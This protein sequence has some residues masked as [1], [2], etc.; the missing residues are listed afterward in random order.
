MTTF[1]EV[2]SVIEDILSGKVDI[3]L[4]RIIESAQKRKETVRK[5]RAAQ[6]RVGD[7]IVIRH[8]RPARFVN[9][10]GTVISPPY[11]DP[12]GQARVKVQV[13]IDQRLWE[14]LGREFK[15]YFEAPRVMSL[16]VSTFEVLPQLK[17]LSDFD[18]SK[19]TVRVVNGS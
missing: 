17:K 8:I 11:I 2:N 10:T 12:K 14:I 18:L 5:D 6:C 4:D 19:T 15:R 16:P 1:A 3:D 7:K 13:D 9:W